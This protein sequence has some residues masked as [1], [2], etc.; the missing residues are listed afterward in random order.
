[1]LLRR[2]SRGAFALLLSL[3]PATATIMGLVLL[4]QVPQPLEIVGIGLVVAAVV[5][6]TPEAE[7]TS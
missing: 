4:R 7:P 2:L 3:L 6:R 5:L 1:V